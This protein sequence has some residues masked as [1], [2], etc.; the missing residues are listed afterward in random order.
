[1]RVEASSN[2]GKS[3]V[4]L[5]LGVGRV[6][7]R[8]DGASGARLQLAFVPRSEDGNA[9]RS[10]DSFSIR[11]APTAPAPRRASSRPFCRGRLA[12]SAQPRPSI[13]GKS[14]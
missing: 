10:F 6:D 14:L 3:W 8:K 2:A 4:A 9:R 11:S 5:Q 1:M 7:G 13:S 12:L